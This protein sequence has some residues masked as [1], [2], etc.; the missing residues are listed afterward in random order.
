MNKAYTVNTSNNHNIILHR[1]NDYS[2]NSQRQINQLGS[3][4]NDY[5]INRE[6]QKFQQF[7]N[8]PQPKLTNLNNSK[9]NEIS[10]ESDDNTI[11]K[12]DVHPNN[13]SNHSRSF[14]RNYPIET[15]NSYN[16]IPSKNNS[17][18]NSLRPSSTSIGMG[19]A[20]Q[21]RFTNSDVIG[22][23]HQDIVTDNNQYEP[24][25]NQ[26]SKRNS[27]DLERGNGDNG[28]DRGNTGN[29]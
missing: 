7:N 19:N 4:T 16:N 27:G 11:D 17:R 26:Y 29:Y 20:G 2:T 28:N 14:E 5:L 23:N 10:P 13:T 6:S 3:T 9:N 15:K 1:E 8:Q 12:F 24:N 18:V 22:F 21:K 25:R